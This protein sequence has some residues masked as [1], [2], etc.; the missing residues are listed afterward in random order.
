MQA[1]REAA[2]RVQCCNN[3][4]Q[5]ALACLNH[6]QVNGF[7]PT[8]A[9]EPMG[10]RSRPRLRQRQ[11]GGWLYNILPYLEQ[12]ALHDLGAGLD[13][14]SKKAIFAQRESTPLTML[15]CPTRRR[16]VCEPNGY[17]SSTWPGLNMNS[18][19]QF[20]RAD[21]AINSGDTEVRSPIASLIP[22]RTSLAP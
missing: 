20:T 13:F 11:P 7:L 9:G 16:P 19:S 3:L 1:A 2:R 6:E 8:T 22:V 15:C 17:A 12:Q 21:Y 14:N 10:G 4:K 5:L 18:P